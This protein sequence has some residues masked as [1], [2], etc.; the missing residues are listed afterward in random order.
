[1]SAST[2]CTSAC[3]AIYFTKT[4]WRDISTY[5]KIQ[6]RKAQGGKIERRQTTRSTKKKAAFKRKSIRIPLGRGP[7]EDR[8]GKGEGDEG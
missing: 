8:R 7:A 6:Q 5:G 3:G 1:L 2:V 4:V